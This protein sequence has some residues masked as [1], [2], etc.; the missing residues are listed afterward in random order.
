PVQRA[1]RVDELLDELQRQ[2]RIFLIIAILSLVISAVG[3]LNIGLA[4][5][6]E[7]SRELVLRRA[8]GATR[9]GIVGQKLAAALMSATLASILAVAITFV[10][11]QAWVPTQVPSESAIALPAL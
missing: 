9:L 5:V 11:F 7:Q 1:D 3:I 2:Q 4:S 10:A 6:A 8:V